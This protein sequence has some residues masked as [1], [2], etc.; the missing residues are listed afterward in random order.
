MMYENS[1]VVHKENETC[2]CVPPRW[3]LAQKALIDYREARYHAC[4]PVVLALL[5]GIVNEAHEK[6]RGLKLGFFARKC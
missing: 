1:R 2:R 5:D 4:V 6:G 3:H